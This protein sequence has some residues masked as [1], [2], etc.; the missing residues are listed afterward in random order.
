MPHEYSNYLHY[1]MKH[2]RP[3][4]SCVIIKGHSILQK[5]L[6]SFVRS[7]KIVFGRGYPKANFGE[8]ENEMTGIK[9]TTSKGWHK[10]VDLGGNNINLK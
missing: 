2:N 6:N 8:T 5:N 7:G 4:L 10:C 1:A 9:N 3:S